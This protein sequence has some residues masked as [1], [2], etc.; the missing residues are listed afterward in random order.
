MWFKFVPVSWIFIAINNFERFFLQRRQIW[1]R[2]GCSL[3]GKC[4]HEILLLTKFSEWKHNS[5]ISHLKIISPVV[6]WSAETLISLFVSQIFAL[7]VCFDFA[8]TLRIKLDTLQFTSPCTLD[9]FLKQW[10]SG[11]NKMIFP[12]GERF[13][14][15]CFNLT[16]RIFFE[17]RRYQKN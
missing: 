4:F 9:Q 3:F 8:I 16:L 12:Y 2:Y 17:Y 15:R 14:N 11:A 1:Q 6:F 13:S 5:F 10:Q 7:K